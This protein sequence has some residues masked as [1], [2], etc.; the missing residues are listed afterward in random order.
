MLKNG[1]RTAILYF[2]I[3]KIVLLHRQ[4]TPHTLCYSTGVAIL[5]SFQEKV[6]QVI[7]QSCSMCPA[8]LIEI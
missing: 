8:N 4:V 1:R 5:N 2:I 3:L 7:T 6:S